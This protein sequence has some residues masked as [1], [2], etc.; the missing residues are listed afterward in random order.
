MSIMI[1]QDGF[2]GY[3]S[4]CCGEQHHLAVRIGHIIPLMLVIGDNVTGLGND[5]IPAW[6][7]IVHHVS[8]M[9]NQDGVLG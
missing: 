9:I 4:T 8:I 6:L 7:S 5:I 3:K 2:L 1:N